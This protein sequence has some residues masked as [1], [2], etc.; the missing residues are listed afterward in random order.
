LPY[1]SALKLFSR[2]V[3]IVDDDDDWRAIEADALTDAG[4][5][6]TTAA[7]GRAGLASWRRVRATIVVTDVEMPF[8]D[9]CRLLAALHAIDRSLPVIVLTAMD[10]SDAASTFSGAFRVIQK[11]VSVETIIAAV[12]EALFRC[13][14]PRGRRIANAARAMIS[15]GRNRRGRTGLAVVAGFGAAAVAA[16]LIAAI[17]GS[18]I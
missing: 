14:L 10:L 6:V 9:G 5:V 17:R 16:V 15:F 2:S 3:L 18:I 11:P 13:R 4:F 12:T 1:L 7:D 8:M